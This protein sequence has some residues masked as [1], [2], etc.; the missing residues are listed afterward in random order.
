MTLDEAREKVLAAPFAHHKAATMI[1]AE[2]GEAIMAAHLKGKNKHNKP[3][4]SNLRE[5]A[6]RQVVEDVRK[7]IRGNWFTAKQVASVTGFSYS[8]S[9]KYLKTLFDAGLAE[10][11][12]INK[13]GKAWNACEWRAIEDHL[14]EH[15]EGE[16]PCFTPRYS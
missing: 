16:T 10:R 11:R 9:N 7:L 4:I 3:R 2:V 15:E 1:E 8:V 12:Y 6:R 13:T 5:L 14:I